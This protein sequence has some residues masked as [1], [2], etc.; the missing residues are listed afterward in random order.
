M[1]AE[2]LFAWQN[3]L[4]LSLPGT[5]TASRE[6]RK[7]DPQWRNRSPTRSCTDDSGRVGSERRSPGSR[8]MHYQL[9]DRRSR[10]RHI[11]SPISSRP[12]R[13]R[14]GS[15]RVAAL[16]SDRARRRRL[17]GLERG[18]QRN[19]GRRPGRVRRLAPRSSRPLSIRTKG[20]ISGPVVEQRGPILAIPPQRSGR[21][22]ICVLSTEVRCRVP[23]KR[24]RF[25]TPS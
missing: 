8:P 14:S 22:P 20:R 25:V 13:M 5:R 2:N 18:R 17:P 21:S 16:G 3:R 1:S 24:P 10:S 6:R 11:S 15:A 23:V 19:D 9:R 7:E 4:E 12:R